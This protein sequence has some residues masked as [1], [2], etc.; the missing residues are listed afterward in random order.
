MALFQSQID[1]ARQALEQ[2]GTAVKGFNPDLSPL[3][4]T[5]RSIQRSRR[6]QEL[7]SVIRTVE[8]T[9]KVVKDL[10]QQVREVVDLLGVC[11]DTARNA[12]HPMSWRETAYGMTSMWSTLVV[13]RPSQ[14]PLISLF[15]RCSGRAHL[16]LTIE[17]DPWDSGDEDSVP[18]WVK[19]PI[20]FSS[21]DAS[22]LA[23]LQIHT[24]A[25]EKGFAFSPDAI[26]V[27]QLDYFAIS[28][29]IREF[30]PYL[31]SAKRLKFRYLAMMQKAK[32]PF[33]P[34][35]FPRLTDISLA[36]A[37]NAITFFHLAR[38]PILKTLE[39][40]NLGSAYT[41]YEIDPQPSV[42]KLEIRDYSSRD[43]PPALGRQLLLPNLRLFTVLSCRHEPN[44]NSLCETIFG[45]TK[46]EQLTLGL[47]SDQ[48]LPVLTYFAD[49]PR[50]ATRKKKQPFKLQK[51]EL[52]VGAPRDRYDQS[53]DA[54]IAQLV[55]SIKAT[56]SRWLVH[57]NELA[58]LQIN[59]MA[60]RGEEQWYREM[61]PNVTFLPDPP[62]SDWW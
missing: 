60:V 12:F 31:F 43:G 18:S 59:N 25:G 56:F 5:H 50:K 3:L 2:L 7:D 45:I 57:G 54:Q 46:L 62:K 34:V 24:S 33:Q 42:E 6:A 38:A 41:S 15:A 37:D 1:G 21:A 29:A 58:E 55:V 26:Q 17:N 39:M 20:Q 44:T 27:L 23:S 10:E 53:I 22:Q 16:A 61:I 51:F 8:A 30:Q 11:A 47:R 19:Q 40:S 28:N 35:L 52:L 49:T 13:D 32:M 36:G 4:L 9:K 48:V 14:A